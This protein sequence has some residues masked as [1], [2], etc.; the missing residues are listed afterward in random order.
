MKRLLAYA[1][2]VLTAFVIVPA[3]QARQICRTVCTAGGSLWFAVTDTVT[4]KTEVMLMGGCTGGPK[5]VIVGIVRNGAQSSN[6]RRFNRDEQEAHRALIQGPSDGRWMAPT[7]RLTRELDRAP[8]RGR[9]TIAREQ[10]A[11]IVR[12]GLQQQFPERGR[13]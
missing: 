7:R 6:P 4:R 11:R 12:R 5:T 2:L 3:V 8:V 1:L 10:L 13:R 9:F